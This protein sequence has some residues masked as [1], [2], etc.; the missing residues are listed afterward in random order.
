MT[1]R[2]DHL[3]EFIEVDTNVCFPAFFGL[4]LLANQGEILLGHLQSS[5]FVNHVME[6]KSN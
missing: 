6:I 4:L 5:A 3:K 1:A 2:G